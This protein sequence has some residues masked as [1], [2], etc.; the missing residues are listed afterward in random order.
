MPYVQ[1]E[2]DKT[3]HVRDMEDSKKV[4]TE[5]LEMKSNV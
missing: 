1:E 4:H 2:R 5:L 3:E